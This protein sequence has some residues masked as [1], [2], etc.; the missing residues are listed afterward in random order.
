[1]NALMRAARGARGV[2]WRTIVKDGSTSRRRP[3]SA[4]RRA[5]ALAWRG[6]ETLENPQKWTK[7]TRFVAGTR[8]DSPVWVS[9]IGD[10]K[11]KTG[12]LGGFLYEL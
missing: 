3:I 9:F 7:T 10:K 11:A 8:R 1:M 5:P 4:H 2:A 12:L 6:V